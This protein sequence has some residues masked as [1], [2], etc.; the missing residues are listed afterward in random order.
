MRSTIQSRKSPLQ[1]RI[2]ATNLGRETPGP[3]RVSALWS[4]SCGAG[5][6]ARVVLRFDT[7]TLGA[8]D[9]PSSEFC[10]FPNREDK[11]RVAGLS[12]L[13]TSLPQPE[14]SGAPSFRFLKGRE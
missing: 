2:P 10:L 4:H 3:D 12:W 11:G 1:A 9:K 5:A 13:L 7:E 8:G 14:I 6:L